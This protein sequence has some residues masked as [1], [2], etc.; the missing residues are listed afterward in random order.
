MT[1]EDSKHDY[2]PGEGRHAMSADPLCAVCGARRNAP[3]HS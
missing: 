2:E 3:V 1:A